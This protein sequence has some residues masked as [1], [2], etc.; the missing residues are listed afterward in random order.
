[1]SLSQIVYTSQRVAELSLADVEQIVATS[2]NRNARD[3]ISG[4]LM[5]CGM[6]MMQLLE[7]EQERINAC[8]E[9]IRR[10]NPITKF[11]SC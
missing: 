11:I 5:C 3:D 8:Y 6:H 10:D 1:M 7:G 2:R 4:V 9:R